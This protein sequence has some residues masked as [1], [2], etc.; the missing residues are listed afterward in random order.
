M[1]TAIITTI[2]GLWVMITPELLHADANL[3]NVNYILGP[4]IITFSITSYWQINRNVR[5]LNVVTGII[6][7]FWSIIYFSHPMPFLISNIIS[8]VLVS[9]LSL[10]K[11][12]ATTRYGGGWR[13]LFQ[14]HPAH[15][16]NH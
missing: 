2:I 11:R 8:G 14:N 1:W 12:K 13:A 3:H 4:L 5:W 7:L 6:L 9:S 15:M 10:V 16:Q